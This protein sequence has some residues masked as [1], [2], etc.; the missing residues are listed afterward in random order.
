MVKYF[1]LKFSNGTSKIV[2][3]ASIIKVIKKH[4]L[5]TREHINTRVIQLTGEQLLI[6]KSNQ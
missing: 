1:K 6:A 4:N 5:A 2:K 3:G